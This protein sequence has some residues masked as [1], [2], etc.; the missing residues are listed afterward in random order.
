MAL[1]KREANVIMYISR[2]ETRTKPHLISRLKK[3]KKLLCI[4]QKT[5]MVKINLV[6]GT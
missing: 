6:S 2:S 4:A 5:K 1:Q 3:E